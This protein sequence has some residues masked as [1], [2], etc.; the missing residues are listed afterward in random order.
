MNASNKSP[1]ECF[2]ATFLNEVSHEKITHTTCQSATAR[3]NFC[4]VCDIPRIADSA[5]RVGKP[6]EVCTGE[7]AV[8]SLEL[9]AEVFSFKPVAE[10]EV[11]GAFRWDR[12]FL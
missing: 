11:I 9:A 5:A 8:G 1:A 6:G 2:T 12:V 10:G 7:L 4:R 3:L